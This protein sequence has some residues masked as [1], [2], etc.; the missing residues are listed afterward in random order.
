MEAMTTLCQTPETIEETGSMK[1]NKEYGAKLDKFFRSVKSG[2]KVKSAEFADPMDALIYG[3]ISELTTERQAKK[4]FKNLQS[5]FIDY[6]D[7]RVSRTEEVQEILEDFTPKGELIAGNLTKILSSVF[8]K[9][10]GMSLKT[11]DAQGK[12][13]ARKE[14]DELPGATHFAVNF[15]FLAALEG[16]AIPLTEPML[17]YL[18]DHELVDSELTQEEIETFLERH[19]PASRGWEFY[20]LLRQTAEAGGKKIAAIKDAAKTPKKKPAGK[21]KDAKE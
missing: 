8:D 9:Y 19:I 17:Q 7:L 12:R 10:D 4:V 3:L 15:C 14:L 5:H 21:K 6:N 1:N 16:H 11:I 20:E 2:Q 18:K 13:Q